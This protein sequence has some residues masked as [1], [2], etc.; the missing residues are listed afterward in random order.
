MSSDQGDSQQEKLEL[1]ASDFY[2]GAE[3]EVFQ[4]IRSTGELNKFYRKVNMT[5]KP[6]LPVPKIDFTQHT[7]VLYC[8]GTTTS[9][10][11][12][13]LVIA[14]QTDTEI[15][16]QTQTEKQDLEQSTATAKLTPFCLFIL[17][18]TKKEVVFGKK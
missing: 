5:R 14:G 2:G 13:S 12:P 18:H 3:E 7:A 4:V 9:Q 1:V 11:I 10:E 8:S 6:G 17:P 15:Q 16:L